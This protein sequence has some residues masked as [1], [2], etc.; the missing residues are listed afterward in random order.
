M[1]QPPAP[2]G[3]AARIVPVTAGKPGAGWP[4]AVSTGTP[5]PVAAPALVKLPPM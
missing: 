2:S 1:N 4:A 5:Q 3:T